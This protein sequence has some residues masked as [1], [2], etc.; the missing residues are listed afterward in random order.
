MPETGYDRAMDLRFA[1][2]SLVLAFCPLASKAQPTTTPPNTTQTREFD[3]ASIKPSPPGPNNTMSRFDPGGRFTTSGTPL[4][5]LIQVAW[6]I[7][8]FDIVGAPAWAG[9]ERYDVIAKPA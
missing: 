8:S 9:T 4:M 5:A 7:K 1:A 2:A 3:A 6:G